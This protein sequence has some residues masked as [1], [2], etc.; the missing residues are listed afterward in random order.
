MFP[1]NPFFLASEQMIDYFLPRTGA[2]RSR[3]LQSTDGEQTIN[4]LI[5]PTEPPSEFGYMEINL[6]FDCGD[7]SNLELA[8]DFNEGDWIPDD[9]PIMICERRYRPSHSEEISADE[10]VERLSQVLSL[11]AQPSSS[12]FADQWIDNVERT[13]WVGGEMVEAERI[14]VGFADHYKLIEV[15]ATDWRQE[16]ERML[17]QFQDLCE[18][19]TG[20]RPMGIGLDF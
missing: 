5:Y 12:V 17:S 14:E 13:A 7:M 15:H 1:D 19:A 3:L 2:L 6:S 9:G 20:R 16:G 10:Q 18:A 8:R 11:S 4:I